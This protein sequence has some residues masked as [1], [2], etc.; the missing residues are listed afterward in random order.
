MQPIFIYLIIL[1]IIKHFILFSNSQQYI[2][3]NSVVTDVKYIT[4][5]S[6]KDINKK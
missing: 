4:S 1:N 3:F 5:I 6:K 2:Y